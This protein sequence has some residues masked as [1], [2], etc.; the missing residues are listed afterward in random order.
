MIGSGLVGFIGNVLTK[1]TDFFLNVFSHPIT[2]SF[3][4]LAKKMFTTV[5]GWLAIMA[6][7]LMALAAMALKIIRS[8]TDYIQNIDMPDFSASTP[9]GSGEA[10]WSDV[11]AFINYAFPLNETLVALGIC[12]PILITA[13]AWRLIKSHIPTLAG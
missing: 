4:W 7:T 13:F 9:G 12:L 8:I 6:A 2:K 3:I 10:G 5:T 1:I 11:L